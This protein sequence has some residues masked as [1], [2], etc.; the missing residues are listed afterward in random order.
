VDGHGFVRL[1][2]AASMDVL[3]EAVERIVAFQA[4]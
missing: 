3:A 2:F 4:R 1:S